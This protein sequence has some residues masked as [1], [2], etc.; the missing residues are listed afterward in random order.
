MTL[1]NDTDDYD[2]AKSE[3]NSAAA[4]AAVTA[5][6]TRGGAAGVGT[7]VCVGDINRMSTQRKRGG[8]AVCWEQPDLAAALFNGATQAA[9][10][11]ADS[12]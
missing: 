1:A 6:A 8:G 12:R 10:G 7:V 2:S 11:C 9:D 5:T 3:P 4:F